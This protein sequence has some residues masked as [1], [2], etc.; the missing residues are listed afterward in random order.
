MTKSADYTKLLVKS[1][2]DETIKDPL[3]GSE[4]KKE[5]TASAVD[6]KTVDTE[7]F[8]PSELK[9]IPIEIRLDEAPPL[10]IENALK[11]NGVRNAS[12]C[13]RLA[14]S[15]CNIAKKNHK[16]YECYICHRELF[17]LNKLRQ[18]LNKHERKDSYKCFVCGK[19]YHFK[20]DLDRHLRQGEQITC[21]YC[22]EV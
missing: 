10:R 1:E 9:A 18:H 21:E 15:R 8:F 4:I 17:T 14:A 2:F 20:Y 13:L 22:T 16:A 6:V 5:P 12:D 19:I 3:A 11:N 7:E